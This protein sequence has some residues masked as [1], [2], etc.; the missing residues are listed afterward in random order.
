[1][2]FTG[3]AADST[4]IFRVF[5]ILFADFFSLPV[6]FIILA[7]SGLCIAALNVSQIKTPM[8][9]G[10]PVNVVLLAT[11]TLVVTAIYGWKLR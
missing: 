2:L 6:V 4:S 5:L 9:S 8:L 3:L 7:I 10:K 11:Y 1:M